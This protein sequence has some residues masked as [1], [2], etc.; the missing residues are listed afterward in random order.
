MSKKRREEVIRNLTHTI[1]TETA[2]SNYNEDLIEKLKV[3][4]ES[5]ENGTYVSKLSKKRKK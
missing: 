2:K 5:V 1:Q 4:L 3:V